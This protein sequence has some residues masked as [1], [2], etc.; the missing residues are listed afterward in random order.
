MKQYAYI[1]F[2]AIS[3]ALGW[4]LLSGFTSLSA[5]EGQRQHRSESREH[6]EQHGQGYHH[7]DHHGQGQYHHD[8]HHG[9]PYGKD[10]VRRPQDANINVNGAGG[11]GQ[12]PVIID[13]D[14]TPQDQADQIYDS[15]QQG[16]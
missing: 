12:Q 9:V 4:Q 7:D 15:Y 1:R 2:L 5:H 16:Q 8:D 13:D 3:A 10:G 6:H 14:N 11:Q